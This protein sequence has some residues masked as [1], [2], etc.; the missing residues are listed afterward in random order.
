MFSSEFSGCQREPPTKHD[1]R[2]ALG[3]RPPA[4]VLTIKPAKSG[5]KSAPDQRAPRTRRSSS[6]T[7]STAP[8]VIALSAM[9]NAG[10]CH[11]RT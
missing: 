9:L 11:V 1:G 2:R 4:W 3:C 10:Q 8:I 7:S 6:N 5:V